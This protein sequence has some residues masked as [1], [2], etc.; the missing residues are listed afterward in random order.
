MFSNLNK[1]GGRKDGF[2][3]KHLQSNNVLVIEVLS[4][5]FDGLFV[6]QAELVFDDDGT[7]DQ[8]CIFGGSSMTMVKLE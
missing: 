8:A 5:L 7:D 2:C 3:L 6:T 4:D 1:Q